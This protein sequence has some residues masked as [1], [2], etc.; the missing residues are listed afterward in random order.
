LGKPGILGLL[1]VDIGL[2]VTNVTIQIVGI[3]EFLII[4]VAKLVGIDIPLGC[5]GSPFGTC[6]ASRFEVA[7]SKRLQ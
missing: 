5:A 3:V 6:L 7:D 4:K 2:K 1:P